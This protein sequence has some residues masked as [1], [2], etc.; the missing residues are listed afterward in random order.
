M[1]ELIDFTSVREARDEAEL[2]AL[3]LR[4]EAA[5][6]D[7]GPVTSGPMWVDPDTGDMVLLVEIEL[8]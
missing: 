8:P 2:L 7:I 3:Q 1:G 4:V 5:L 6:S